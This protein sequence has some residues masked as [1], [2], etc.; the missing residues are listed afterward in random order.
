MPQ[1]EVRQNLPGVNGS[2][3]VIRIGHDEIVGGRLDLT[4]AMQEGAA[5][6]AKAYME[7]HMPEILAKMD[8]SAVA[9]LAIA[10]SAQLIRKRFIDPPKEKKEK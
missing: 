5:Q 3:I 4:E 7:E 2:E 1:V 10:E 9:N 6:I 8:P